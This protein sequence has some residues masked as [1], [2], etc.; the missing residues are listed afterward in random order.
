[1]RCNCVPKENRNRCGRRATLQEFAQYLRSG[2]VP[3]SSLLI[4]NSTAEPLLLALS[5]LQ[6]KSS[7]TRS[8]AESPE[9]SQTNPPAVL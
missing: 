6:Y 7:Q 3:V 8:E 2:L 4:H 1:M 5:P 9:T